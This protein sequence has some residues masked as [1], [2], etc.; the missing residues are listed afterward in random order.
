MR[1]ATIRHDYQRCCPLGATIGDSA[2]IPREMVSDYRATIQR[3]SQ[4]ESRTEFFS[5]FPKTFQKPD[6]NFF[7]TVRKIER[8]FCAAG[9]GLGGGTVSARGGSAGL[10]AAGSPRAG[11]VCRWRRSRGTPAGT[12]SGPGASQAAQ[13]L[14]G[15]VQV[16]RGQRSGARRAVGLAVR[17]PPLLLML[18]CRCRYGPAGCVAVAVRSAAAMPLWGVYAVAVAFLWRGIGIY[19]LS[20]KKRSEGVLGALRAI[21]IYRR[22]TDAVPRRPRTRTGGAGRAKAPP[23]IR[24]DGAKR[25]PPTRGGRRVMSRAR[26]K[27]GSAR[28]VVRRSR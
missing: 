10:E 22:Y 8:F 23:G 12:G 17:R 24:P 5:N 7:K 21:D 6:Q 1:T 27:S 15:A 20:Y 2:T 9:E 13:D 16:I 28:A 19:T 26:S 18:P 4:S 14:G 25:K 3:L 11:V